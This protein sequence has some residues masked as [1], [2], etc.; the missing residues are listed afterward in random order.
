MRVTNPRRSA[1]PFFMRGMPTLTLGAAALVVLAAG[2]T[3][4]EANEAGSILQTATVTR[5]TIVSAV[6]A[7]GTIEP[8]RFIEVKSQAGGEILELPVE[9]GDE[10][11]AGELLVRIDPR[12][13]QNAHDQ[14]EADL[15][16][17][18][19]QFEVSER[20]LTR[21][22]SLRESGIV[23]EEE[24]ESAILQ[25]A[26]SKAALVR[27][28]TNLELAADRLEDV[29]LRAPITGT[30]VERS[31][32][33]GQVIT[34]T[35]DLTGGTILMLMADLT[36]VQVRTLV[37]ETDIGRI[38]AGLPAE[39]QVEAYPNRAFQ[40]S[41]LKIEPQAVVEQNVTMFVVLTR[42]ANREG[43]LK[44]GMNAD[45]QVVIG[46][47][48]DVLSLP[49]SAIKTQQ[50]AQQLA[51]A[52]GLD[53]DVAA[54]A[55]Q[56]ASGGEPAESAEVDP[57]EEQIGGVPV[58]RIQSMSQDERR[59]WF[60]RLTDEER[61]R[62]MQTFRQGGGPG[63]GGQAG[64]AS[65]EPRPAFSFY[66]DATGMLALKPI[67]IGLSDFDN[68]QIVSGLEEGEEV[69]SVPF[70]LVQQQDLLDRMRSRSALPGVSRR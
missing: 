61:Q 60:G 6:E 38:S 41:V 33:E 1:R 10:V 16:V 40:G 64:V 39:I 49:N 36:E 67:M 58:S 70:S 51:R 56:I 37:D 14:A 69:V 31:I 12:D 2:C 13:V 62:M 66:Y 44:P 48:P 29:V 43:L 63:A 11:Q 19:A 21:I 26:N 59:E 57:E 18:R 23:T 65:G 24:L 34:G 35:R 55:R 3:R 52:L 47:E 4:G 7:T 22:Q 28:E 27:A 54:L 50:E 9:L 15:D 8:I 45:V 68:T 17:A 20:Q 5:Q 25:H 42:I 30:I 53:V 46:R 32:E